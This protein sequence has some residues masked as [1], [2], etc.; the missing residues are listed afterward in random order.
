[1]K[2]LFQDVLN[3]NPVIVKRS[4]REVLHWVTSESFRGATVMGNDYYKEFVKHLTTASQYNMENPNEMRRWID[5][6]FIEQYLRV[7]RGATKTEKPEYLAILSCNI[8]GD[9]VYIT[10]KHVLANLSYYADQRI[11][12]TIDL[13]YYVWEYVS[14]ATGH[15][16]YFMGESFKFSLAD[17]L[18]I[19]PMYKTVMV[20]HLPDIFPNRLNTVYNYLEYIATINHTNKVTEEH[21]E[22]QR[23]IKQKGF[24]TEINKFSYIE[25]GTYVNIG[26]VVL[27]AQG[28]MLDIGMNKQPRDINK[29]DI[30]I[31]TTTGYRLYR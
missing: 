12:A 19:F 27:F 31:I 26:Q 4:L 14:I 23:W 29:T 6:Q 1:M 7:L 16:R 30:H 17:N 13:M 11:A 10:I 22:V 25:H 3:R 20:H 9:S 8:H 24:T 2:L 18:R 5:E 21:R 28:P 15:N